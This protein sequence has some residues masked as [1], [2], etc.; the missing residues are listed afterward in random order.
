MS[1]LSKDK[2]KKFILPYLS[3]GKRGVCLSEDKRL[4]IVSCIFYRLKT[5]CQW[6]ELPMAQYFKEPY[7]YQAVF[8]HFSRWCRIMAKHVD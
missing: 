5:G 1:I 7:S 2:I 3:E 6:R 4:S 8:H